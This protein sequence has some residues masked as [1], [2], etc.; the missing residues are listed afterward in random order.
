LGFIYSIDM[1]GVSLGNSSVDSLKAGTWWERMETVL[2][3]WYQTHAN[4]AEQSYYN[5][6]WSNIIADMLVPQRTFLGGWCLLLPCIYLLYDNADGAYRRERGFTALLGDRKEWFAGWDVRQLLVLSVMAGGLPLLHTHSFLALGL[7]SAG[8]MIYD[9]C[10]RGKVWPWLLYGGLACLLAA[11]QLFGWTFQHTTG[12]SSFVYFQFNWV[13][14]AGG[15]GL[16]DGYLWFWIK[17]IGVPVILLAL[18]LLEKDRKRRFIASGAFVIFVLAEFIIFQPNEYDNNKLF[19]VWWALCA[20]LAADYAVELYDKLK[21]L[22]ARCIMAGMLAVCC[23]ATG[24]LS[25]VRE[26]ISDYQMFSHSDVKLA[27]WVEENTDQDDTF[28][29]WTQHI[30]PV[31][32]LTGRDIVCGPALW[33]YYHGYDLTARETDIRS[34][35]QQPAER[36]DV[37]DKYSIDYILLG[38]YEHNELRP[39]ITALEMH[40]ECVYEAD[41]GTRIFAV[42]DML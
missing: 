25:I 9:L 7:I 35:Y 26:C 20:V 42:G 6:R 18:S 30:N 3:G 32:A 17:N 37:L 14:N 2:Y 33:L 41:D 22:R 10:H 24:T 27:E 38:G 12:N 8:W 15:H 23:F 1:L 16:R 40:Y 5:L 34:F 19:Y 4:H 36:T 39:N 11:P 21:G 29:C 28:M 13:N 31:S